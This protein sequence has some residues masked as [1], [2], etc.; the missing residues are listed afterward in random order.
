MTA[1]PTRA[2][3]M[4][5]KGNARLF[6]ALLLTFAATLVPP[7][8]WALVA[9]E[10]RSAISFAITA[11]IGGI[12][13]AGLRW[14]SHGANTTIF[15]REALF[16]VAV[17][18]FALPAL[19]GLP[20]LLDG[21][22]A[23]PLDAFFESVSGFTT[24]GATVLTDIEGSLTDSMHLWR[25]MTHWLGGMGIMVLFVA[26][27]P[28]LGVGGKMLFKNEVPGPITEGLKPRMKD[29]A[30]ALWRIYFVLTAILTLAL[31]LLGMTLHQAVIHAMSTL[32]TGGFSTLN[33]SVAGFHSAPIDAVI[34]LF[35][36][37]GGVNFSLYFLLAQGRL[38]TVT[39]DRE[40]WAYATIAVST[41]VAVTLTLDGYEGWAERLRF[42]SFNVVSILTTTGFA[43]AD[44]D[45]WNAFPRTII[46]G[47]MFIGAC[48]GSTAGGIKVFRFLVLFKSGFAQLFRTF[49]PQAVVP[50]K[51][52]NVTIADDVQAGISAYFFAYLTIFA[53]GTL[54]MSTM[55]PDLESAMTS[56]IASLGSVGPGLSAVGPT[57]NFAWIAAPGK[58]LLL[59]LMILGRLELYTVLVVVT[60]AFW[61][62]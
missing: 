62:R 17:S 38:T 43:T 37:L 7:L 24:T 58:L 14:W 15:R 56:V 47:V 9:Q 26:V 12:G 41:V 6:A 27:L 49:R 11:A 13:G 22:F 29:T 10:W 45:L 8:L 31:M 28:S 46:F 30:M 5:W 2:V 4:N 25:G 3:L 59:V 53:F 54:I 36:F 50:V 19:G 39:R 57:Q 42:A 40:L 61:K 20:Y 32:S 33:D 52:R 55:M 34:T 21:V 1:R 44:F 51:I 60:P 16:V 35:M 23:S 18:W 48:A